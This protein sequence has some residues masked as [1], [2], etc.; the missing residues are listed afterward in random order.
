[1]AK[2]RYLNTD[3]FVEEQGRNKIRLLQTSRKYKLSKIRSNEGIIKSIINCSYFTES[4][5]LGRNQGDMFNNTHDQ[6]GFWDLVFMKDGSYVLGQFKS[7]DY[8]KADDVLAGFSVATVLMLGGADCEKISTAITTSAKVT[9]KAPQTALAVLK[10]GEVLQIVSDGRTTANAG[11]TGKQLRTFLKGKYDI[12]LLVQLDGGGSSEMVVDGEIVNKPSDGSERGMFNGIAFIEPDEQ[13]DD[14]QE[15]QE[16]EQNVQKDE[17]KDVN[18]LKG[19][20]ISKWQ[21]DIDLKAIKEKNDIDF[22]IIRAGYAQT[23]DPK[24][25]RNMDLCES[26]GIPYGVY[27]Y[28]YATS[29][30]SALKEAQAC[31]KAITGRKL[32]LPL[33]Y[34]AEDKTL[35]NGSKLR[36]IVA[37]FC[38]YFENRGYYVGVYASKS[39]FEDANK[40]NHA[41]M[42]KYDKWV[43]QWADKLTYSGTCGIWQYSD[44]GSLKGY[45]G[46]LDM[47][48]AFRD[49]PTIIKS[50]GLNGWGKSEPEQKHDCDEVEKENE[51]LKAEVEELKKNLS[52]WEAL[53][54]KIKGLL[55]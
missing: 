50:K 29:T 19:I 38:D 52:A 21:G 31:E 22:V 43:A 16:V 2:Y 32:L 51:A 47:N 20:D 40:L 18:T 1:M 4:Y 34:D 8:C 53:V 15:V 13:I 35:P 5:V 42:N 23:V 46:A 48:I 54:D 37:M 49:Y 44:K 10:S 11:L 24:A 7:W 17:Q 26:L 33:F 39:W 45:D 55:K 3:I 12:D 14:E 30:E 25:V 6:A 27:W 28:S 36:D 9:S 41:D